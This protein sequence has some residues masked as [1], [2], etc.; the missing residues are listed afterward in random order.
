[1]DAQ[2]ALRSP[3]SIFERSIVCSPYGWDFQWYIRIDPGSRV[4]KLHINSPLP[5]QEMSFSVKK[6]G[7]IIGNDGRQFDTFGNCP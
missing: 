6:Q 7:T 4:H 2:S 3:L 1:M 5:A